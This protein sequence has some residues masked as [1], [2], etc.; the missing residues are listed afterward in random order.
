MKKKIGILTLNGYYN[1]GNRL[2]NYALEQTII[3]LG[4]NVET[5]LVNRSVKRS[6]L[7]YFASWESFKLLTKKIQT[8]LSTPYKLH[9]T[10]EKRKSIFMDFS[11]ENIHESNFTIS[12]QNYPNDLSE[13]YDFFIVGSDQVWNPNNLHGTDF[14]FLTFADKI[15]R[16]SYSASF[17]VSEISTEYLEKYRNWLTNMNYISVREEVGKEIV[18]ELTGQEVE[19]HVD[20][21]MLLSKKEWISISKPAKNRPET[22]YLLTY[23]L[24]KPNEKV[25]HKINK[26]AKD[27]NMKI[28]N[29][30]DSTESETYQTGPS[31]YVDYINNASAFFT[32]SFHGVVFSIILQTPFLVYE[33]QSDGVSMYSRIETILEKFKLKDREGENFQGDVFSMDFEA[34]TDILSLEYQKSI[35][36]LKQALRIEE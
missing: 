9:K 29:M 22:E 7:D 5:I 17:G 11:N 20:P 35:N 26:L 34:T 4:F 36:Y 19:V 30:G 18:N 2:Q 14:Y 32:D 25:L 10:N 21:T 6:F 13:K 16:I 27:N 28:I 1:Y 23:F 3:E 15:K 31:E 33:R 24:D 12:K 8:K